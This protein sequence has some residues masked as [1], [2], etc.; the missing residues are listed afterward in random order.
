MLHRLNDNENL[1]KDKEFGYSVVDGA[2]AG[3]HHNIDNEISS[4]V[5][6]GAVAANAGR[7]KPV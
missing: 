4:L 1:N 6:D 3:A 7:A 2:A 5:V